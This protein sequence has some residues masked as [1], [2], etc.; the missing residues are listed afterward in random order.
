MKTFVD[1]FQQIF[2]KNRQREAGGGGGGGGGEG[3]ATPLNYLY[4]VEVPSKKASSF[5][6]VFFNGSNTK[7]LPFLSNERM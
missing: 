2:Q 1:R 4:E 3:E 7:W 5:I 6:N